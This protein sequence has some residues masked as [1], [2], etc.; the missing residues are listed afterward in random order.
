MVPSWRS[1]WSRVPGLFCFGCRASSAPPPELLVSQAELTAHS[2]WVQ[3]V[4][5]SDR[6]SASTTSLCRCESCPRESSRH[7]PHPST[8]R[9]KPVLLKGTQHQARPPQGTEQGICVGQ[10]VPGQLTSLLLVHTPCIRDQD[11]H[12]LEPLWPLPWVSPLGMPSPCHV[13]T[14]GHRDG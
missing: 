13:C 11:S 14:P 2:L 7:T 6:A 8:T 3:C 9:P 1:S 5:G 12:L 4:P 10:R